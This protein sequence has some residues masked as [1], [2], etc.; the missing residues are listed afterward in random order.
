[1]QKSDNSLKWN[2]TYNFCGSDQNLEYNAPTALI[3]RQE[4]K[5]YTT[6]DYVALT[7]KSQ[8]TWVGAFTLL[9]NL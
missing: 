6:G 9:L 1:M 3:L 2:A 4:L 7:F 5:H 8:D